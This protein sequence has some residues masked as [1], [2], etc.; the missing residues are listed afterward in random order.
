MKCIFD[1]CSADTKTLSK[2]GDKRRREC[3][4]GHRFTTIEAPLDDKKERSQFR[5][6]QFEEAMRHV[7]AREEEECKAI[8]AAQG[9]LTQI[10]QQ[11]NRSVSYV[12]SVRREG[13]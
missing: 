9:T 6:D 5:R 2:R 13:K 4:N 10:A 7:R 12:W 11:F 3:F 8:C 1:C